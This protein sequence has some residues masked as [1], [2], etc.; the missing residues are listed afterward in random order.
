MEIE[1][2]LLLLTRFLLCHRAIRIQGTGPSPSLFGLNFNFTDARVMHIANYS[3]NVE[4]HRLSPERAP[5]LPLTIETRDG[6]RF[7]LQIAE[8]TPPIQSSPAREQVHEEPLHYHLEPHLVFDRP[9]EGLD[10]FKVAD[11]AK[12]LLSRNA[13][14]ID[15]VRCDGLETTQ[16]LYLDP[17]QRSRPIALRLGGR[18]IPFNRRTLTWGRSKKQRWLFRPFSLNRPQRIETDPRNPTLPQTLISVLGDV[19]DGAW[20]LTQRDL[21]PAG[22]F[23]EH[24]LLL[25][26]R[27]NGDDDARARL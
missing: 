25:H 12:I 3:I 10:E 21:H 8:T 17:G 15:F 1:S 16:R 14:S 4:N 11:R 13:S 23:P 2:L 20:M 7:D 6:A 9:L 22:T 26:Q 18:R 19:Y 24:Y 5:A 27:I